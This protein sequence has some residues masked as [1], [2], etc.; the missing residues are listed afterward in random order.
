V[1]GIQGMTVMLLVQGRGEMA[2]MP[3]VTAVLLHQSAVDTGTDCNVG[4]TG[5]RGIGG[6]ACSYCSNVT[7]ERCGY[8]D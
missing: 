7:S 6:Y 8:R 4:S 3:A 2:V 5:L 1:L